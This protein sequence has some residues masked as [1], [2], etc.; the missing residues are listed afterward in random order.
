MNVSQMEKI[1][2]SSVLQMFSAFRFVNWIWF[3]FLF[4]FASSLPSYGGLG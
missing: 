3:C 1:I 2:D 4:V